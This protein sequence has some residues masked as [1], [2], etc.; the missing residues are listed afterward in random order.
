MTETCGAINKDGCLADVTFKIF[1]TNIIS[2]I[3][4]T[5]N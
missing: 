2:F 5:H 1:C 3:T 4:N